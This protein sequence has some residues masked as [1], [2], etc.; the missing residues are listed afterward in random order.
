MTRSLNR[1]RTVAKIVGGGTPAANDDLWGGDVPFVTPP[2][3]RPVHGAVVC[4]TER[5]LTERGAQE[6]SRFAPAG[7]V[8]VS[9]RAPIGYVARLAMDAAFNQG[10]L[11]VVPRPGIVDSI[12][13]TWSLS[14]RGEEMQSL[15]QGTT[16]MEIPATSLADMSLYLPPLPE[17]R[18]I[19]AYLDAETLEIDALV[20]EQER[21]IATLRE[22]RA[23]VVEDA[24]GSVSGNTPTAGSAHPP[25]DAAF[26][27]L[28]AGWRKVPWRVLL[29]P[30]DDRNV[31]LTYP[32]GSLKAS[33]E[34]VDRS[35]LEGRQEPDEAYQPR[36]LLAD[37]GELVVNPMWLS[38]GCIGV[39]DMAAAVSPDYRVF[40][41]APDLCEPRYL[42]MLLR[43]RPFME[44]YALLAKGESTFARRVSQPDLDALPLPLPPLHE[45]RRI[46]AYLDEK[47][48]EIDALIAE[49]EKFISVAKERRAAVITAAVT[50]QI[51]C[52]HLIEEA[53]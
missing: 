20:A 6:G 22:R 38:G 4:A 32:M 17:Q 15:G 21:L 8:I 49:T 16:F 14:V 11:A 42:Q 3:L 26:A 13:L 45:Q 47:M 23:A 37:P 25:L 43:S 48:G 5:S 50:G 39:S 29:A 18:A 34:V 27:S 12:F 51:D 24:I 10:C 44:Q 30:R 53:L 31:D 52:T 33:G 41:I 46:V 2:D 40:R 1:V 19:A 35:T 7:S 36:Y 28:P 9:K